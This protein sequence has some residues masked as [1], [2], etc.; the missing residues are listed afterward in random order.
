MYEEC[1]SGITALFKKKYQQDYE[2][3]DNRLVN[4]ESREC[5][6]VNVAQPYYTVSLQ[7]R[8]CSLCDSNLGN[9]SGLRL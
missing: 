7:T 6:Y 8:F 3:K 1:T 2:R 4:S 5:M 9:G